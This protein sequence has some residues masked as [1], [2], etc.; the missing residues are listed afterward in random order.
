MFEG[1]FIVFLFLAGELFYIGKNERSCEYW[2]SF[3]VKKQESTVPWG[4]K[5]LGVEEG[6]GTT[7]NYLQL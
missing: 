1:D 4:M 6:V 7:S 5:Q 2:A 3:V